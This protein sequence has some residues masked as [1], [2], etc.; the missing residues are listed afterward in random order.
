MSEPV[1]M[2][3]ESDP[4][5]QRAYQAARAS[6]RHFWRELSWERRRIV[7]GLDMTMVKLPF[8][9]GPRTDGNSEFEHM[10]IGDIGFDGDSISGNLLNAPNWLTSVRQ[11]DE[12]SAPVSH[13]TDWMM[14]ADGHA[15][16]GFNAPAN[17]GRGFSFVLDDFWP[18][19]AELLPLSIW[20]LGDQA[21]STV[22]T[23]TTCSTSFRHVR[24]RR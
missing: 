15:Y 22:T 23:L 1:F 7:P 18:A 8:T 14:T 9:D 17:G 12:V 3:D 5:M 20:E 21:L 10:W 24:Q 16:G 6:F 13:L 19:V 4:E 11:G 2:F